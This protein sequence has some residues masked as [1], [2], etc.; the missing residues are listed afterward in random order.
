M[1]ETTAATGLTVQQWDDKFFVEHTQQNRF[2]PEMGTSENAIIQVK[3][4]LTKKKGESI[5]YALVNRLTGAGVENGATLEGNE[6]DLDSR[7]FKLTIRERAHGVRSSAWDNQISAIDLRKAAK[8]SLKTWSLENTR[9][10]IIAALGSINGVAYGAASEAQKDAWLVDNADR[11]LFGAAKSNNSGND[12]SASL[13]NVDGTNDK[14]TAAA[15]SLMKR[16]ARTASPK[17]RPVMSESSGRY[18]YTVYVPSLV[19]RDLKADPVITQA[20]RDVSLRMQNER[21]FKGGDIEWD[22]MIF[23]EIEDIGVLSGVGA[24]GIDVGP[25]YFCGAQAIGYGVAQ[26]WKSEEEYFDYKRKKGCAIMEMGGFEKMLFGSGADDL[27]DLK[28][29]GVVTGFFAAVADA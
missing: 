1:A 21:L 11:V 8:M 3:E 20:Q 28:D 24:A 22:G 2:A 26:R 18:Y 29:H 25:V 16:M 10:R 12:H 6:E 23:K 15:A 9:D 7:S 5:T 13:L 19:F 4:D 27:D 14:L 17:I